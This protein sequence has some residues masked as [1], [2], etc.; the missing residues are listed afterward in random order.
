MQLDR[1]KFTIKSLNS[2]DDDF[3]QATPA[4]RVSMV[5]PLTS[6]I[7]EIYKPGYAQRRLQR[8]VTALNRIKC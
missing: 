8:N 5:W 3:V 6:E 7:W 1:S 4:E 2:D